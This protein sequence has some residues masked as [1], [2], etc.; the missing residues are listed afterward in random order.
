MKLQARPD[1]WRTYWY[2][3][4]ERLAILERRQNGTPGPWSEDPIFQEYKFCNTFRATDRISQYLIR[5]ISYGDPTAAPQEIVFRTVL[6]RLFSKERTWEAITN[7]FG[8][9]PL[10]A[11]IPH[12]IE[13]LEQALKLGAIYTNAFILCAT[14]TFG[15]ERKHENH[16][17]LLKHMFQRENLADKI[18]EA[19]S[20]K[21]VF[22]ML[23]GYPLIGNFMA[24]QIAIDLN[25]SNILAFSENDFTCAGPGALRG[26]EKVFMYH[27]KASPEHMVM[28]MVENQ[29]KAFKE[30]GFQFKGLFGRPLQAIDCQGLFCETDKY[31]RVAFPELKSERSRIKNKFQPDSR[32]L[33]LFLP[34]KWGLSTQ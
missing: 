12:L 23:K 10:I 29:E 25:Y 30:F 11:D 15:F 5:N 31:C 1:I 3:A 21:A 9:Q 2:F 28:H 14:N 34:P 4:A 19:K 27:G 20:L 22:D 7:Y 13:P 18:L 26:I 16:I 8:H 17:A 6:F 33:P 32:P 24:Y